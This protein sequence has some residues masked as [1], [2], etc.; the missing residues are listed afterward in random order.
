LDNDSFNLLEISESIFDNIAD[1]F[2]KLL[3][4]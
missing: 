4:S 1:T 3:E 2:C